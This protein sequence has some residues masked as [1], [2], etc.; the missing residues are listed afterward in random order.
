MLSRFTSC[1]AQDNPSH[2][3][4]RAIVNDFGIELSRSDIL[5]VL[6]AKF[7]VCCSP[8]FQFRFM[9]YPRGLSG[10]HDHHNR[11]QKN[12]KKKE[13]RSSSSSV[14]ITLEKLSN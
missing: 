14:A 3:L 6:V 13:N 10:S 8:K 4:Q 11:H 2:P 12:K 7:F 9:C 1:H 5:F